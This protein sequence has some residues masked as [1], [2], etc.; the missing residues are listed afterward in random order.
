[1][2][3][4]VC[5]EVMKGWG[6][7][8]MLTFL[9]LLPLHV[10]TLHRCLVVLHLCIHCRNGSQCWK[11][12]TWVAIARVGCHE[13]VGLGGHVKVPCASSCSEKK[14]RKGLSTCSNEMNPKP[15]RNANFAKFSRENLAQ[16]G[17]QCFALGKMCFF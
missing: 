5:S 3:A 2:F 4:R 11:V 13:G 10:A 8:G 14:E 9:V 1:M 15:T 6:G 16:F 12:D 17:L 7:G